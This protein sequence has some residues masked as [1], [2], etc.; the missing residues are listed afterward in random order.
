[1][2]TF[3]INAQKSD[4]PTFFSPMSVLR[5]M[6]HPIEKIIPLAK[7]PAGFEALLKE[8][9]RDG[10]ETR[11]GKRLL[12]VSHLKCRITHFDGIGLRCSKL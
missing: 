11:E 3:S 2:C 7:R 10:C 1:M 5:L 12:T 9:V 6:T 4:Y 8:S